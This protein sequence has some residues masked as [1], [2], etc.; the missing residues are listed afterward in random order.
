[1]ESSVD[2]LLGLGEIA[3]SDEA[4]AAADVRTVTNTVLLPMQLAAD[5]HTMIAVD[6][7]GGAISRSY[8]L[9]ARQGP[10]RIG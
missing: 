1:M 9:N 8:C 2:W 5:H 3:G 4:I 7:A 6:R 10:K